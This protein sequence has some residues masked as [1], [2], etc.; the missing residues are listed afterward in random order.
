[1]LKWITV[2]AARHVHFRSTCS[3]LT[4]LPRAQGG[5]KQEL[6]DRSLGWRRKLPS[7]GSQ[8]SR[9]LACSCRG[10][11]VYSPALHSS[12]I[13]HRTIT[14][15]PLNERSKTRQK[16]PVSSGRGVGWVCSWAGSLGE[17]TACP[18]PMAILRLP[19]PAYLY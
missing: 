4:L 10:L 17:H 2:K 5:C 11:P 7:P 1:M 6:A 15:G 13:L 9:S 18:Q 8:S 12:T 3:T 19:W 14:T 16:T